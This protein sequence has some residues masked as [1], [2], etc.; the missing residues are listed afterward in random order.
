MHGHN[1]ASRLHIIEYH[2]NS[3]G[4]ETASMPVNG[5]TLNASTCSFARKYVILDAVSKNTTLIQIMYA[6][7]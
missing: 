7:M 3:P 5:L 2:Y 6:D 1:K 4:N